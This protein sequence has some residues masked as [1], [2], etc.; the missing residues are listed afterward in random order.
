MRT[1][2]F[3]A[4]AH[5]RVS[6]GE[7]NIQAGNELAIIDAKRTGACIMCQCQCRYGYLPVRRQEGGGRRCCYPL[8]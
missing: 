4:R 1:A 6:F 2:L 7:A 8:G 3:N 5:D